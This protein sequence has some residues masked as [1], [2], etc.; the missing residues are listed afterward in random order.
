MDNNGKPQNHRCTV[1]TT[2][3]LAFLPSLPP[4]LYL[5]DSQNLSF[6]SSAPAPSLL[7]PNPSFLVTSFAH[8][9]PPV[10]VDAPPHRSKSHPSRFADS[11]VLNGVPNETLNFC[12]T[13]SLSSSHVCPLVLTSD[14]HSLLAVLF[15]C[16]S[17]QN[18]KGGCSSS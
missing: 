18:R 4:P 16:Q 2:A 10:H 8:S 13:C 6:L 1:E 9:P 17:P 11:G 15:C 7:S 14:P 5:F 3:T 12:Q